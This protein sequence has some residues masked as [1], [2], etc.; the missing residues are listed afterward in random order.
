MSSQNRGLEVARGEGIQED[1]SLPRFH[2]MQKH[3]CFYPSAKCSIAPSASPERTV[4]VAELNRAV[5][6][7]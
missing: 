3:C 6:P 7:L 1:T 4:Q 2:A 5:V